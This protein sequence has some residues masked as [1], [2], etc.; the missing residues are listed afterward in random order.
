[1]Y[2]PD[3]I[4]KKLLANKPRLAFDSSKDFKAQ[5]TAMREKLKELLGV[6]REKVA[7]NLLVEE[8]TETEKYTEYRINYDVEENCKGLARL[9][10][11]KLNKEKY[12][13][14]VV[15][16]GHGT[17]MHIQMGEN[18]YQ[19]DNAK[20]NDRDIAI[21]ALEKGFATICLEQRGFG[22]RRTK[23]AWNQNDNG[24]PR[25]APTAMINL[26]LGRTLLGDRVWDI[27][28][29][30]DAALTFPQIDATRIACTGNSGGGTATYYAACLDERITVAM[31]SCGICTYE[32]S[33]ANVPH[34]TCNYVPGIAKYFRMGDLAA[35]IAPRKLV[36]VN[37][38][39]DKIF[40][41][42]GVVKTFEV[43]KE[44]YKSAGVEQ[45]CSMVTGEGGH[46]YF[47]DVAW[48]EFDRITNKEFEK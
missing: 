43:I 14:V 33:I 9:C 38:R 19:G 22:E 8:T 5:Q 16:S 4:Q 20:E 41:H 45:N 48:N 27:S 29:G 37:G 12:P 39:E 2:S 23:I 28:V 6:E 21:Q 40:L 34:C 18:K 7:L 35:M 46:R 44:I 32:E 3:Y 30:I 31:P 26:L 17:G 24:K 25:C 10:I 15:L 47:K 13:L 11:P 42:E 1:M 36:V